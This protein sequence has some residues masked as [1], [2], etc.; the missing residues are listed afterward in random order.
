VARLKALPWQGA[1]RQSLGQLLARQVHAVLLHGAAGIGKLDLALD[2]AETLLCEQRTAAAFAEASAARGG[3][4]GR[5][6]GCALIAAGNHPDLRVVRP[7][8]L[9][10]PDPRASQGLDGEAAVAVADSRTRASREIRIEQIRELAEWTTLT[11]HRGGPRVIVIEPAESLNTPASNALLKVLEEP[12]PRTVFLL[13]SHRVDETLPTL[14]SR[15]ALLRVALPARAE[16]TDWLQQQG[17]EQPQQRL[18]EAGGAPLLAAQ[19]ERNGLSPE[20]HGRLLALLRKGAL[21]TAAELVAAVPREVPVGG[22]VALFQRWGWDFLA[23]SLA[24]VVRYHPQDVA[25]LRQ[26]GAKWQVAEACSWMAELRNARSFADHPL[27]AKLAI[28]GMLLSYIRSI[29]DPGTHPGD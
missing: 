7:Q 23:F 6:A 24:G 20:L 27:N 3:A 28:E 25:A 4:C 9:G 10:E 17:I 18:I 8:A 14:R 19:S 15:C 21:L 26:L 11:T 29:N 22:S 1:A 13:V 16:A 2:M 12:P 5:C